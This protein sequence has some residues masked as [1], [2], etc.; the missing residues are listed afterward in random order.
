MYI[1]YGNAHL[2]YGNSNAPQHWLAAAVINR[3]LRSIPEAKPAAALA[4][5]AEIEA[6]EHKL[7]VRFEHLTSQ[8]ENYLLGYICPGEFDHLPE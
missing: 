5:A 7:L 4:R 8:W 1:I 6:D 3:V 2:I